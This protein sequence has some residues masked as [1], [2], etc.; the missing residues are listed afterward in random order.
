MSG[1]DSGWTGAH[2]SL[3]SPSCQAQPEHTY[4]NVKCWGEVKAAIY[5]V[6]YNVGVMPSHCHFGP[7]PGLK[8]HILSKVQF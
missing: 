4:E 7:L 2:C 3:F 8:S 5:N 1:F 6:G